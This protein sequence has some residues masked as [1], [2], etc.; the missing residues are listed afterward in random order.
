MLTSPDIPRDWGG[1][2]F[3]TCTTIPYLL[4]PLQRGYQTPGKRGKVSAGSGVAQHRGLS[5]FGG[6]KARFSVGS[7]SPRCFIA[8]SSMS[9]IL[10]R[11]FLTNANP[12]R[13]TLVGR[14][15]LAGRAAL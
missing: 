5:L 14:A 1:L 15:A 9:S 8:S 10:W 2:G 7:A 13:H 12:I 3:P 4:Q 6:T 11:P